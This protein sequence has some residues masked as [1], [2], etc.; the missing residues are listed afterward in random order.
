MFSRPRRPTKLTLL[1]L[2]PVL[3]FSCGAGGEDLVLTP[4]SFTFG[5]TA[6]NQPVAVTVTLENRG[7]NEA[8]VRVDETCDCFLT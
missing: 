7:V 1:C 8:V 3:L 4:S 6:R 5:I 2:L